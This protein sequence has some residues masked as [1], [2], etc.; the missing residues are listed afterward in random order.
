MNIEAHLPEAGARVLREQPAVAKDLARIDAIWTDALRRSG[1]PLLFG[2]F[3]IADAF[4][5]P[6]VMR[7]R[8]YA[9]PLSPDAS[10]YADR[11]AALPAVR[12]WIDAAL[13]EHDFI[14]DDEPYRPVP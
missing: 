14:A 7:A 8:T 2:A 1:G 12:E 3:G 13:A 11:V 9:L 5:A 6:V 10:G 4:Y